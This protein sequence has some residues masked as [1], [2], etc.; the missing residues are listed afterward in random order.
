[1]NVGDLQNHW[2]RTYQGKAEHEVS[3]T[4]ASPEPSLSLVTETAPSHTSAIID[5][6]CG[7]S[8]LIDHLLQRGYSDVSALDLSAAALAVAQTRLREQAA[9]VDWIVADITTWAAPKNRYD[10]WHDRA[11]FHF[12]VQDADRAAYLA[13]MN[14]ALTVDGHAIIATF[15]LDGP[16]RCSGLP[17]MR[18]DPAALAHTLGP[19]FTLIDSRHHRHL[20]PWGAKQSFQ[21]SIFR[22]RPKSE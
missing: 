20:T 13:R 5:I 8:H 7:S 11:T 22:R 12:L 16:E 19:D 1:M 21:F 17:V 6:G 10:V 3:W 9:G 4:Q 18:Y 15:D 14:Q 2:Q